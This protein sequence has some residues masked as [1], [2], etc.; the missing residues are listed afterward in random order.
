MGSVED[1]TLRLT[2]ADE[3]RCVLFRYISFCSNLKYWSQ[4]S[5]LMSRPSNHDG[6]FTDSALEFMLVHD[7]LGCL[8]KKQI[9]VKYSWNA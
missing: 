5:K 1:R 3:R 9:Q 8:L 7:D 2:L 6:G 4:P